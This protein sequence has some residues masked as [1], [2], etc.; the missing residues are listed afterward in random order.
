LCYVFA[1]LRLKCHRLLPSQTLIESG[2]QFCAKGG[3]NVIYCINNN[4]YNL[5][6][7]EIMAKTLIDCMSC[8]KTGQ[9]RSKLTVK[10]VFNV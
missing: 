10:I 2:E 7:L 3:I 8:P 6:E 4:F 5:V 9:I 1:L